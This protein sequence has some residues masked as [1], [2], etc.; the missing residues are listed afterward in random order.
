MKYSKIYSKSS[1][2]TVPQKIVTSGRA[3]DL[4]FSRVD[5]EDHNASVSVGDDNKNSVTCKSTIN[6]LYLYVC[7]VRQNVEQ[8]KIE[9]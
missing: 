7:T 8:V 5:N 1:E 6:Q 3:N 9:I 4:F 2:I